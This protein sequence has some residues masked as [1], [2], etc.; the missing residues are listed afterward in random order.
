[1]RWTRFFCLILLCFPFLSEAQEETTS[2]RSRVTVG[3]GHTLVGKGKDVNGKQS[4]LALPMWV[5]DYDYSL[6][7]KWMLG[8]H[9]DILLETFEVDGF[10]LGEET[11]TIERKHPVAALGAVSFRPGQHAV[12]SLGMGGE[13]SSSGNYLMTRVGFEYGFELP[14][15]WELAPALTYDI[16]WKAYDSFSISLAVGK[17]F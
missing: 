12:Y 6:S 10:F 8:V 1:M 5:I 16:K 15:E 14:G 11:N 4:W 7:N 17:K 9:S 3:L 2:P 13:F